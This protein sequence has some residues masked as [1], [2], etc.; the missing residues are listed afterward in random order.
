M[1]VLVPIP[2]AP[3]MKIDRCQYGDGFSIS[4][5]F[6]DS[7]LKHVADVRFPQ[8][9]VHLICDNTNMDAG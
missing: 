9:C 7:A 8:N 4:A 1:W 2:P 5:G 6:E 3:L